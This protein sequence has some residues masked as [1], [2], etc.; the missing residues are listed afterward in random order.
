[1]KFGYVGGKYMH[2]ITLA[3]VELYVPADVELYDTS[4]NINRGSS[5]TQ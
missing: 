3:D 5:S 2:F 1:M 4:F